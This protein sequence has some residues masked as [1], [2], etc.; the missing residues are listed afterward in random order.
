MSTEGFII[1]LCNQ[2]TENNPDGQI[3]HRRTVRRHISDDK[4]LIKSLEGNEA[5]SPELLA[6]LRQ[7]VERTLLNVIG[8]SKNNSNATIPSSMGNG[9]VFE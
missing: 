8:S 3:R 9:T 2:C 1:C 7:C 6:H 4:E 5:I